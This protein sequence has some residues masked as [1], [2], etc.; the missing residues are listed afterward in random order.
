MRSCRDCSETKPLTQFPDYKDIKGVVRQRLVC[1]SCFNAMVR[2]QPSQTKEAKKAAGIKH[3]YGLTME[4]YYELIKDGCEVCGTHE[5]LCIDHDHSCCPAR[6]KTCGNCIRGVLC[7]R[8]NRAEGMLKGNPDEA[9]A[10]AAYM[11][12]NER[13][14]SNN[15]R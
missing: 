15:H 2:S 3:V 12:K 11:M 14:D 5:K 13:I 10:L 4:Q 1:R 8:H 6:T 7:D 9:I